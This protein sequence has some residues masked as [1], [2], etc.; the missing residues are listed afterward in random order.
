[1]RPLE[2]DGEGDEILSPCKTLLCAPMAAAAAATDDDDDD[3]RR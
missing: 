2:R 3:V 1:M